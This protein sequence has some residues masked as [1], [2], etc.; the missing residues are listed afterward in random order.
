MP[1]FNTYKDRSNFVLINK[2]SSLL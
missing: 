2:R 1:S